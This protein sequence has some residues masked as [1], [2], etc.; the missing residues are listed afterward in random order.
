MCCVSGCL[1]CLYWGLGCLFVFGW[2]VVF[3]WVVGLV[4]VVAL[5]VTV[6]C[7]LWFVW[8]DADSWLQIVWVYW[9][10]RL[11]NA[12]TVLNWFGL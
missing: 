3:L 6:C 4:M 7:R 5:I 11:M 1:L 8:G 12:A 9:L 10:L 2:V